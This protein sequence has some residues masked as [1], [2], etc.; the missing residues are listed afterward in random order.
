MGS[1]YLFKKLKET[2]EFK[3]LE[4]RAH[5]NFDIGSLKN[6]LALMFLDGFIPIDHPTVRAIPLNGVALASGTECSVTGWGK[7]TN[8]SDI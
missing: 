5:K 3:V 7:M 1:K 6:D 4:I 2:L 8:V